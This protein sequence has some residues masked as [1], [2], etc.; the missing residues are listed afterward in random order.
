MT[1]SDSV[2]IGPRYSQHADPEWCSEHCW[3]CNIYM[4]PE[5][6]QQLDSTSF[7]YE[8][9]LSIVADREEDDKVDA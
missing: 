1:R 3:R 2:F 9:E 6:V 8:S 4:I 5:V 7:A